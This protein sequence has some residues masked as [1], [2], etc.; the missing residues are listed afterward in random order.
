[1]RAGSLPLRR[2]L[3]LPSPFPPGLAP[4]PGTVLAGLAASHHFGYLVADREGDAWSARAYDIDGATLATCAL[5]G[6][7][8]R[9]ASR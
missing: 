9:C 4:A 7:E 1:M 2:L 6:R 8:M 5:A 3:P